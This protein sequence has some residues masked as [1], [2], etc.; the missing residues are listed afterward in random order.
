MIGIYLITN[1]SNGFR[2]VGQSVDIRRR[3]SFH[4]NGHGNS[5]VSRAIRKSG[6][7]QFNFEIIEECSRDELNEREQ[8][9]INHFDCLA[10]KGYNLTTGGGQYAFSEET[11]QKLIN[12]QRNRSPEHIARKTAAA[13][14]KEVREKLS[15]A[16]K[17]RTVSEKTRQAL[18]DAQ[19]NREFSDET[20]AKMSASAKAR[21]ADPEWRAKVG[22]LSKARLQNPEVKAK[23]TT[24]GKKMSD[25]AR[26][27]MSKAQA[28]RRHSPETILKMKA[29][30]NTP[31][32]KARAA[33]GAL[34]KKQTPEQIAKRVAA[35]LETKRK[36]QLSLQ[37]NGGSATT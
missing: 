3:K 31:E 37:A 18:S 19:K 13:K 12:A 32:A 9:W 28:G 16:G 23:F 15:I 26:V 21:A 20:R 34:G 5:W 1:T 35:T 8:Y 10:P 22:A 33:S 24:A 25:A 2:Y 11:M 27:N 29:E 7:A 30:R 4:L 6:P 17:G 36:K 14:S